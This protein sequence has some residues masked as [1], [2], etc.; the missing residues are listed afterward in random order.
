MNESMQNAINEQIKNELHSAYIYLSMSAYFE[1]EDLPGMAHWMRLQAQEEVEHAMKF[2]AFVHDRGGRV[3]L[4]AIDKPPTEWA[5][6]LSVFQAALDHERKVTG[7][8]HR[9]YDL[10]L[11]EN[12]YPAQTMLH[13]FIDE[14]VE[15]ESSAGEIVAHLEKAKDNAGAILMLDS[16]LAARQEE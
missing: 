13:W 12:D 7:M 15:E 6:P 4:E 9:L 10:A 14:Q 5:S 3:E 16:R 2:F 11:K 1:S 8:I